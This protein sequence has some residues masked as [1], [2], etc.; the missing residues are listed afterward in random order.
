MLEDILYAYTAAYRDFS[1]AFGKFT[2]LAKLAQIAVVSHTAHL[3]EEI[4][5]SN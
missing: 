4:K 2:Q 3:G 1:F 5:A